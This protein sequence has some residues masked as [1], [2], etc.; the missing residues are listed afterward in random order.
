[1]LSPV[2]AVVGTVTKPVTGT[3]G[4]ITKP[5][6]DPVTGEKDDRAQ[7]LGGNKRAE[8]FGKQAQKDKERFGGKDQTGD[9]PLGL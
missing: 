7:V 4:G 8:D 2:G 3:V 9:N 1:M 6:L 5:I